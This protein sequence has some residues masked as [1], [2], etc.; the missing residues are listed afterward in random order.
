MNLI[1][2]FIIEAQKDFPSFFCRDIVGGEA[3]VF[4][5]KMKKNE[6]DEAEIAELAKKCNRIVG[7]LPVIALGIIEKYK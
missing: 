7:N 1:D 6:L 4:F 5:A 3:K 2:D